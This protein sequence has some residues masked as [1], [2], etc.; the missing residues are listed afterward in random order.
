VVTFKSSAPIREAAVWAPLDRLLL[1]TDCP[2]LAPV[3][4]RGKRNEPAYIT[5]TAA[6]VAAL[7]GL[8]D[9]EFGAATTANCRALF[10]LQ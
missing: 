8:S 7:R 6:A 3:P 1:E 2:Y 10:R 9:D 4:L 5:H